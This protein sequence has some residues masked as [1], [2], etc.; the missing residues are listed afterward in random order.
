M[1]ETQ[2]PGYFQWFFSFH[3]TGIFQNSLLVRETCV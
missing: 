1:N 3:F 2:Y